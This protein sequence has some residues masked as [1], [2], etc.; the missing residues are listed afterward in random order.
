MRGVYK[1][2]GVV[3][4]HIKLKTEGDNQVIDI[5]ESIAEHVSGSGLK[6]GA[7][8]VFIPGAT[9]GITTIEYEPGLVKDI[10]TLFERIAPQKGEYAHNLTWGDG[11]GCSHVRASLLGPSITIPFI[12]KKLQLGKWQQVI[13][14]DFDNR[15]RSRD[16]IVQIIG[17]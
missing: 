11:N 12:N 1:N 14:V 10:K 7:V 8:T 6:N 13:V 15:P 17:E 3:T 2:M 4:E 16:I 9:G 5:T